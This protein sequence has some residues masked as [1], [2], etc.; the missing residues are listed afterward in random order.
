MWHH[1]HIVLYRKDTPL[2][3]VY[4]VNCYRNI[5]ITGKGHTEVKATSLY[6]HQTTP[7]GVILHRHH[8]KS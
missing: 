6:H 4:T 2:F 1:P 5:I 7:T 8:I 3:E